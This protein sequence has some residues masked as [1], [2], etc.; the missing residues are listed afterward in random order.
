[1][2]GNN[3][4]PARG[5]VLNNIGQ[6]LMKILDLEDGSIHQRH[7]DQVTYN[8]APPQEDVVHGEGVINSI[9]T[10]A[11]VEEESEE[12]GDAE[13]GTLRNRPNTNQILSS[14]DEAS[15]T[16]DRT[17]RRRQQNPKTLNENSR[18]AKEERNYYYVIPLCIAH[19]PNTSITHHSMS[20]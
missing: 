14:T 12:D 2:K 13:Q 9:Q 10:I 6:R 7:R 17:T 5:I 20:T 15:A 3:L 1:M 4:R 18:T 8:T 11:D 16:P 19:S